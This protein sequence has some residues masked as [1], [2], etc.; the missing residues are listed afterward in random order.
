MTTGVHARRS[1]LALLGWLTGAGFFFYA[2]VLRVSPSVMVEELMRDFAASGA[3]L[4]QLSAL[5]FY[6]YAGMQIPVGMILDRF[7]PRR[8]I[9]IAALV[10]GA[11]TLGF[12]LAG[13][14]VEASIGRFLLGAGAAFSLVGAVT[15]AG[16]WLPPARFA[17]LSGLSMMAGMAGGMLGQAPLR[18]AVDAHGWRPAMGVLAIGGLVVAVAAWAFV[19]DRGH[20]QGGLGSMMRGLGGVLRNP[21]TWLCAM[22]GLGAT[23][24]LLAFAGLWGVPYLQA[25]HGLDRAGAGA[26]ASLTFLGWGIGA[27]LAGWLSD[28]LHRRRLPMMVGLSVCMGC[29]AGVIW[30]PT[31]VWAT[32]ALCFGVGL[33]GST[34]IVTFALAREANPPEL[35]AT[36]IGL[37]NAL[38]TGAGAL[39]QPAIGWLLD[40]DWN[41][42]MVG[43]ARTYALDAY[44]EA[45]VILLVGL[46]VG[47]LCVLA[48]REGPLPAAGETGRR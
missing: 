41:G 32:G 17:L 16:L 26:I 27:P 4:G 46:A 45:F 11:G 6:G 38:V 3:L 43:G 35:S 42:T 48:V 19:R 14:I 7:G 36:A 1:S 9:A 13:D 21:Q 12:A 34:Q 20:G 8:P 39:F 40:R 33:G 37:V 25:L 15:V 18:L 44:R 24:P 30:L 28:R 29:L 22:A 47:L 5:Y 31:P 10:C 2:W 23:G